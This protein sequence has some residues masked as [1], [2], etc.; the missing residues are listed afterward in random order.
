VGSGD[1]HDDARAGQVDMT[2]ALRQPGSTLKPFVYA[3]AFARGRTAAD[4]LADVPASFSEGGRGVY[5]PANFDGGYQ[6]PIRAPQALAGS[7]NVPAIRLAAELP[8]GA[9]LAEL[10]TLGFASLDRDA[11]HYG[12]SLALGSGEV[13][14]RELAAAYVALARGGE[15]IPLRTTLSPAVP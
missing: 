4:L 5:A 14:L 9:L 6:G 11:A 13:A 1:F 8:P 10:K 7:L 3:M 12:L 15:A 2:R